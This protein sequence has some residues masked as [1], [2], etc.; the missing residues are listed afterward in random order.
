MSWDS[1]VDCSTV[2]PASS[3]FLATLAP[4]RL[5]TVTMAA[6][7]RRWMRC[8]R[9]ISRFQAAAA[10]GGGWRELPMLAAAV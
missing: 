1:L 10:M 3:S 7:R 6:I 9:C 4:R 8:C 2:L 5:L